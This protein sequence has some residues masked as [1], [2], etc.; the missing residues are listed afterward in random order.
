[1]PLI[2]IGFMVA[3]LASLGLP[4][5]ERFRRRDHGLPRDVPG[6]RTGDRSGRVRCRAGGGLH[7][8]GTAQ[9]TMF[10]PRLERWNHLED[11]T[12]VDVAAM[13]VLIVPIFVFGVYPALL[14]DVFDAGIAPIIASFAEGS[15]G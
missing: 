3:G 15:G 11:A 5:N 2:A 9:R 8:V 13:G 6:L 10:G 1:M 12:R 14:T 7:P 4:N